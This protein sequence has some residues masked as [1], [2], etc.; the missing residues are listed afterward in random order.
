M[1][2]AFLE[3]NLRKPIIKVIL[4]RRYIFSEW[5][6]CWILFNIFTILFQAWLVWVFF[7]KAKDSQEYKINI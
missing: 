6:Y 7:N 2:C 1:C 5:R 3:S 4:K